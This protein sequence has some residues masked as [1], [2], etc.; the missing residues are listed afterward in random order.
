MTRFDKPSERFLAWLTT[1]AAVLTNDLF[2]ELSS[3]EALA[4]QLRVFTA[5]NPTPLAMLQWI[6]A[7]QTEHERAAQRESAVLRWYLMEHQ[8]L[9]GPEPVPSGVDWRNV[10]GRLPDCEYTGGD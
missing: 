6:E 5:G 3:L 8:N 9:A 1:K 4:G 10:P 7:R 2:C